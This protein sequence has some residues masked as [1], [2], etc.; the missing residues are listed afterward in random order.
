MDIAA[1]RAAVPRMALLGNVAPLATLVRGTPEQVFREARACVDKVAAGGGFILSAGGRRLAGHPGRAHRR[2]RPRGEAVA[3]FERRAR[4]RLVAT[5][6]LC[7][8]LAAG[9]RR[10]AE[11]QER[12]PLRG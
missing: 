12:D 8:G 5:V 4:M 11:G 2:A 10:G 6:T 3:P 7:L 9:S 1:V